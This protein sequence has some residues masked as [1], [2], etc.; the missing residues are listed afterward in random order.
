[1]KWL[2]M[3]TFLLVII[4][5][6]NWFLVG[7][8]QWDIGMIFGGPAAFISRLIYILVGLSGVYIVATHKKS[9]ADCSAHKADAVM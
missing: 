4:G 5:A 1:M 8:F 2:H 9:C 7:A 3:V 6:L